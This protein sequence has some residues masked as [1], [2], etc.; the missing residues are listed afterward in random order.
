MQS[1]I[2][3][4]SWDAVIF[5]AKG[6]KNLYNLKRLIKTGLSKIQMIFNIKQ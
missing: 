4:L 1:G 6:Q 5:A 2:F 3:L